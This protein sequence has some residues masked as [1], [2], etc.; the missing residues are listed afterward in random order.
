M[1]ALTRIRRPS[2][3]GLGLLVVLPLLPC[4]AEEPIRFS[5]KDGDR[6]V[7]VGDTL[8]ERDQRWPLP[9]DHV[10]DRESELNSTFRNL[11]WSGDT[12]R[13]SSRAARLRPRRARELVKQVLAAKPTVLIVGYGMADLF[14][15]EA[16]LLIELGLEPVARRRRLHERPADPA[17]PSCT[18]RSG[19]LYLTLIL[20]P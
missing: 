18:R 20:Q 8:I 14:D 4:S 3:L 5:F 11:G 9:R 15:G 1:F 7:L 2:L 12:V 6:I 17:F 19:L 16:G 13:G 10:D